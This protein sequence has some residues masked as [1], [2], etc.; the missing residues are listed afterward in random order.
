M[1]PMNDVDKGFFRLNRYLA[2][3]SAGSRRNVENLVRS[4]RISINGMTVRD[5]STRV[6]PGDNVCLDGLVVV[7]KPEVYLVMNKPVGIVCAVKDKYYPTVIDITP[8]DA[9]EAG[10]FPVG[11]LDKDSEG[12]LILTNDGAFAQKIIHPE[13]GIGKTYEVLL[14]KEADQAGIEKLRMGTTIEGKRLIPLN[15]E[16]V[17]REPER[18]WLS[19]TLSEGVKR[20]I[21]V[22]AKAA[23]FRVMR[24]IR[25]KIGH[26]ELRKIRSGA[27]VRISGDELE[28]MILKGGTV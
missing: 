10:V 3:S 12:L 6:R 17:A 13:K 20:E 26:L 11:R 2:M 15:V 7:P 16:L 19:I 9:V 23:G 1:G 4:G 24:L 14:E 25:R 18:R 27:I 22:M 8:A 21:R 28:R 5:L